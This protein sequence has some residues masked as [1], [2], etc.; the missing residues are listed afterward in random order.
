MKIK[1]FYP[2]FDPGAVEASDAIDPR[3]LIQGTFYD[4]DGPLL[5]GLISERVALIDFDPASGA[6]VR[7]SRVMPPVRHQ[8]LHRLDVTEDQLMAA[9]KSVLAIQTLCFGA[10]MR[11]LHIVEGSLGT[12]VTWA[13]DGKQLLVVPRAG[14]Q[15]NA[16]YERSSHSLQFF[17][18]PTGEAPP[19]D[20]HGGNLDGVFTAL[21]PDIVAH[22]TAHALVDA[23]APYLHDAASPES[24]ALHE[25]IADLTALIF[26]LRTPNFL[27]YIIERHGGDGDL[28]AAY[29]GEIA[30]EIGKLHAG[31]SPMTGDV[32]DNGETR[33][34]LRNLSNKLALRPRKGMTAIGSH[35]PHALSQVMSGALFDVFKAI[36]KDA[37]KRRQEE[38]GLSAEQAAAYA[39]NWSAI[40]LTNMVYRA[41]DYLPPGE[42]SFA[43]FGRAMLAA[44][45]IYWPA[46]DKA[47]RIRAHLAAQIAR[48][49]I[50]RQSQLDPRRLARF[51]DL[52]NEH[53]ERFVDESND[54][55]IY[56]FVRRFG[57]L[58]CLPDNTAF[59]VHDAKLVREKTVFVTEET[60]LVAAQETSKARMGS[61]G[62]V[63]GAFGADDA[64]DTDP[65]Q[66]ALDDSTAQRKERT[67]RELLIKVSWKRAETLS[68]ADGSERTVEFRF[69]TTVSIDLDAKIVLAR[70]TTNPDGFPESYHMASQAHQRRL[71]ATLIGDWHRRGILVGSSAYEEQSIQQPRMVP[72]NGAYE[73]RNMMHML[74]MAQDSTVL[75]AAWMKAGGEEGGQHG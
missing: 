48:R 73:L 30:E 38:K 52:S 44:D 20:A 60:D 33:H 29:V 51:P 17:F 45:R 7:S 18:V 39:I 64:A 21:S 26:S 6:L 71:R 49:A 32:Q 34:Y 37:K 19:G 41:L 36:F 63:T 15:A 58:F 75:L 61:D 16:F 2:A 28:D 8:T 62:A 57:R 74:H 40:I 22:E 25:A 54:W 14:Y 4:F 27:T 11:T 23:I 24:L 59:K 70:L 66:E 3:L 9:P 56:D 53:L 31:S 1:L 43:D 65:A 35:E 55:Q 42:I 46:G 68:M 72:N 10:V 50:C 67:F 69:G 5:D 12:A 13:F 47:E